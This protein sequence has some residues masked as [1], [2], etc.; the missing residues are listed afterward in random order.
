MSFLTRK[1]V[2]NIIR[3]FWKSKEKHK[4]SL[5]KGEYREIELYYEEAPVVQK[6]EFEQFL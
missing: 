5:L 1:Y 4:I 6:K 3:L 2:T